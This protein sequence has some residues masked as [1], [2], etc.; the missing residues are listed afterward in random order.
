[1]YRLQEELLNTNQEPGMSVAEY[2]TKVNSLWDEIDDLRPLPA[3]MCN[4]THNFIKIQQDQRILTFLMKLDPQ[5]SQLRFTLLMT[6]DLPHITEVY[7]MLLQEE[8]H[9]SSPNR[10]K[11]RQWK[12]ANLFL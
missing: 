6:N 11:Y 5:Y 9:K 4:P 7:R 10:K 12:E 8:C 2:F 1:M 3:C